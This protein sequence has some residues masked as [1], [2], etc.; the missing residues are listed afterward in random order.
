MKT[1]HKLFYSHCENT[2]ENVSQML[3]GFFVLSEFDWCNYLQRH[4]K[5]IMGDFMEFNG[6]QSS[7]KKVFGLI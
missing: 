2:L 6:L 1:I 5:G 3:I 4:K 7:S